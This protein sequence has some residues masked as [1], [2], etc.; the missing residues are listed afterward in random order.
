MLKVQID[1]AQK[2]LE[3]S[4]HEQ[5]RLI[6]IIFVCQKNKKQNETWIRVRKKK[7]IYDKKN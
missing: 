3:D 1:R 7:I 4:N 2:N 6:K 5:T